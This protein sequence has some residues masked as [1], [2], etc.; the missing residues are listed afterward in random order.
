MY[1]DPHCKMFSVWVKEALHPVLYLGSHTITLSMVEP[2]LSGIV[3]KGKAVGD[4][5]DVN[6]RLE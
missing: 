2:V 5:S 3:G 1:R 6:I 4:V